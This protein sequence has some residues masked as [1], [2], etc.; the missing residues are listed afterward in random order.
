MHFPK[1]HNSYDPIWTL[2]YGFNWRCRRN[3]H[4]PLHEK[5]RIYAKQEEQNTEDQMGKTTAADLNSSVNDSI[6]NILS[7]IKSNN[8]DQSSYWG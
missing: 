8:G 5:R 6:S 2:F 1:N 4:K 7:I 3:S